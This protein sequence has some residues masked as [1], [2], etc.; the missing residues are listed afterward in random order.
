MPRG[1]DVKKIMHERVIEQRRLLV[2]EYWKQYYTVAEIRDIVMKKMGLQTLSTRTVWKDIQS[3]LSEF[4][5]Y[6]VEGTEERINEQLMQ[7]RQVKREA[8]EMW[9][10]SK[11]DFKVK[12]VRQQGVPKSLSNEQQDVPKSTENG[13]RTVRA[14]MFESEVKQFGNPQYL[15]TLL[16]AMEQEAKLMGLYNVNVNVKGGVL[17]TVEIR[18]IDG[19]DDRPLA[20]SEAEVL[21][22]E[23]LTE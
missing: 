22:R 7:I 1:K 9:L 6:R 19:D 13:I 21:E 11:E 14:L 18:Y 20:S 10:K 12:Q 16:K 4:Q 8:W 23:G 17:A 15:Q 5:K 3:L 2:S